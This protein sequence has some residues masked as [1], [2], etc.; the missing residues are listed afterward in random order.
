MLMCVGCVWGG[1]GV[2]AAVCMCVLTVYTRCA[3]VLEGCKLGVW[4]LVYVYACVGI[5]EHVHRVCV[6]MCVQA[7]YAC[8]CIWCV[9]V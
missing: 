4:V 2:Y 3:Y 8:V 9:C 5:C 7:V 1:I 6:Y